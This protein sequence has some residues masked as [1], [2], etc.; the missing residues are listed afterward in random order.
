MPE[1][2]LID[3]LGLGALGRA[4]HDRWGE[5][6]RQ[7]HGGMR[8]RWIG[9]RHVCLHAVAQASRAGRCG[10][11][12]RACQTARLCQM[13]FHT[14]FGRPWP[15]TLHE[16]A[17]VMPGGEALPDSFRSSSR[18]VPTG[19]FREY[20]SSARPPM[21]SARKHMQTNAKID[22][23]VCN[24]SLVAAVGVRSSEGSCCGVVRWATASL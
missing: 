17:G 24:E 22:A 11:S 21:A 12:P 14:P 6:L 15:R 8:R 13:A 4:I 2:D 19:E 16:V 18:F 7:C 10:R 23:S 20:S 1:G 9:S 5:G 3:E